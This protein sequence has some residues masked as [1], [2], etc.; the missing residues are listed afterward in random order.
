[1][2]RKATQVLMIGGPV[3]GKWMM[4]EGPY[5]MVAE[6]SPLVWTDGPGDLSMPEFVQRRYYVETFA[7][8]GFQLP[9]AICERE[10]IGGAER[11]R[12]VLRA[13]LQRDVAAAMGVLR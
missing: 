8:L 10:F 13:L 7:M 12:A 5:I 2:T 4:A 11:D 9:V 6:P 1:V 3:D